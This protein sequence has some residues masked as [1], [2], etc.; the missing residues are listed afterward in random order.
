MGWDAF[1][2]GKL[3]IY[4]ANKAQALALL[5]MF[6]AHGLDTAQQRE[7]IRRADEDDT[8]CYSYR[9]DICEQK[10]YSA[11]LNQEDSW[12]WHKEI[13]LTSSVCRFSEIT[14]AM[15]NPSITTL[16]GLL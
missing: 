3:A 15:P 14:E 8:T 9:W 13:G 2:R 7:L 1:M 12:E 16:D 5:D 4:C 11:S 10:L 6:D